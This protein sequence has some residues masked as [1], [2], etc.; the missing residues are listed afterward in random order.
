MSKMSKDIIKASEIKG[1]ISIEFYDTEKIYDIS[2]KREAIKKN[3]NWTPEKLDKNTYL[4][5]HLTLFDHKIADIM[6][7]GI[8]GDA[9]YSFEPIYKQKGIAIE[10]NDFYEQKKTHYD[11]IKD[12]KWWPEGELNSRP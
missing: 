8:V 5:R 9:C 1:R 7:L 3:Q 6:S 4:M 12:L 10:Y 2:E 11:F